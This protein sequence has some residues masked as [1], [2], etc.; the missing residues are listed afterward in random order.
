[1]IEAIKDDLN[2][3]LNALDE[4]KPDET[5]ITEEMDMQ[6]R[7]TQKL[8]ANEDKLPTFDDNYNSR[9]LDKGTT[10]QATSERRVNTM[11]GSRAKLQ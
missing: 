2:K 6:R 10:S 7:T 11:D 8:A 3:E 1:M 5:S 4:K 9:P